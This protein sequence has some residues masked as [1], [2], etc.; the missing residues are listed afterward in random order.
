MD[1]QKFKQKII[2]VDIDGTL[3]EG[4]A[5]TEEDCLKAIPIKKNIEKVNQMY[6][7]GFVIMYTA[8][9]E[10][11][12]A[13]TLQWLRENGVRYHAISVRKIPTDYYFDDK[14]AKL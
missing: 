6:Q 3:C 13:A 5:W 1:Y 12:I 8:R 2:C 11:L 14:A 9:R 10:E 4:D 7:Y